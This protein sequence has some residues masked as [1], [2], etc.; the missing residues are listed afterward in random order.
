MRR[1]ERFW[2]GSHRR[3][4]RSRRTEVRAARTCLAASG[5]RDQNHIGRTG[6]LACLMLRASSS[7][8]NVR[9]KMSTRRHPAVLAG[10]VGRAYILWRSRL[11]K[12]RRHWSA[13]ASAGQHYQAYSGSEYGRRHLRMPGHHYGPGR[14]TDQDVSRIRM[15]F[16]RRSRCPILRAKH[17][18]GC[19]KARR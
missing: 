5:R 8:M 6:L 14:P 10:M 3:T 15:S 18:C 11:D 13:R 12:D 19:R 7:L 2:P 17:E 16:Q 9:Q 1:P 4:S